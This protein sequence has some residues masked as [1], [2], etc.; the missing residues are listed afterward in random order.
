[1][2]GELARDVLQRLVV[3]TWHHQDVPRIHGLDVH[4]R[5]DVRVLVAHRDLA[6]AANDVAE[7]TR[8]VGS[9]WHEPSWRWDVVSGKCTR[10]ANS[11][12]RPRTGV[13]IRAAR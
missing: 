13:R 3:L 4:E 7:R 6:R 8:G 1:M 12:L 9:R 5:D 2:R 10:S 11:A